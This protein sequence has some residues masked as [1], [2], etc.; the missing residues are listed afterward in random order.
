VKDFCQ[1]LKETGRPR[2]TILSM[3]D[4]DLTVRAI[5]REEGFAT[6]PA[7][8]AR[9]QTSESTVRR[10]LARLDEEGKI[11]R[12]RGGA[13]LSARQSIQPVVRA[14]DERKQVALAEKTAVARAAARLVG[15]GDT[16][17]IGGGSTC[18]QIPQFLL[19]RSLQ[20]VTNS[21]AVAAQF[22]DCPTTEVLVTG[23]YLFPRHRLLSGPVTL[24][25][26]R[27]LHFSWAFISAAA[28]TVEALTDW[29]VM[30]AEVNREA[31]SRAERGV[32]LLDTTKFNRQHLARVCALSDL[33]YLICGPLPEG[34]QEAIRSAGLLFVDAEADDPADPGNGR[35]PAPCSRYAAKSPRNGA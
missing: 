15:D 26:L 27:E 5:L 13:V 34:A 23:G 12:V 11:N 10:Q 16:V 25:N 14:F 1:D 6:I 32:A 28:F 21:L 31:L 9:L 19:D 24:A 2:S 20:V 35:H 3:M 18:S 7:L 22:E 33:D 30:I 17:F 4:R 8:A 29:N